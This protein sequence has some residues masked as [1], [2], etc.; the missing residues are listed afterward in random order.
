MRRSGQSLTNAL[1]GSL[2][3]NATGSNYRTGLMKLR[4]S[5][6]SPLLFGEVE[7]QILAPADAAGQ[8]D[9]GVF[10]II[11]AGNQ[12]IAG[13]NTITQDLGLNGSSGGIGGSSTVAS[14]NIET[15]QS[16]I[17][18]IKPTHGIYKA[19]LD[20]SQSLP[21]GVQNILASSFIFKDASLASDMM[22]H[23]LM[24]IIQRPILQCLKLLAT[25]IRTQ[26]MLI[27]L[28]LTARSLPLF[29]QAVS[30]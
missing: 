15:D 11:H 24:G 18:I 25:L 9:T 23:A 7:A 16:A 26:A 10:D 13:T 4:P 27:S 1:K 8:L 2:A 19:S 6:S 20:S 5:T 22:L 17:E 12:F 28:T 29:L 14:G 30:L 3:R 21:S